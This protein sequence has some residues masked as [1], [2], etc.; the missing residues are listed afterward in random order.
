MTIFIY[1]LYTLTW[2]NLNNTPLNFNGGKVK[3]FFSNWETLTSD[4]WILQTVLGYAIE[5]NSLPHQERAIPSLSF[6]EA[7][8]KQ[9]NIEIEKLL[10][11][12]VIYKVPRCQGEYISNFFLRPKK[13]NT[14]RLIFNVKELNKHIEYHHFKMDTFKTA[15]QL[16]KQDCWFASV[17]LKDAYYSVNVDPSHRKFLRF[18]WKDECYEFSCLPMGLTSSPR[19]FTKLLKPV[20]SNLHQN[21]FASVIYIDDTLLAGDTYDECQKNVAHTVSLLDMLG[22]TVHPE[23]SVLKPVQKIAFLGFELNSVNMTVKLLSGKADDIANECAVLLRKREIKIQE[24]AQIIGKMVAAEPAVQYA[25]LHYKEL[26]IEKDKQLKYNK[27]DYNAKFMLTANAI[28]ELNWWKNNIHTSYMPLVLPEISI[29]IQTD[30]SGHGWGAFMPETGQKTGGHWSYIE[31]SAHINILELTAAFL[32][33]Q[34]FCASKT[35]VHICLQM[36]NMVAVLYVN[37]MGGRKTE[38]NALCKQIWNWCINRDIWVSASHLPGEQNIHADRLSRKLNDD[39]EWMLNKNIFNDIYAIFNLEGNTDLFASR[40]N[41]QLPKYV[42]YLPDPNAWAVDA[43]SMSWTNIDLMYIFPPFSVIGQV[44]TKINKDQ[45]EAVL[46]APIWPAQCWF[47]V[48]L[49]MICQQ[50][51]LIPKNKN[52]LIMPTDEKRVHHLKKL[53]LG[54]FRLSGNFSKTKTYRRKLSIQSPAPGDQLHE[55]NIGHISKNG[56][57]FVVESRQIHL[58]HL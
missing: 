7:E 48:L 44:L 53:R 13:D 54:C 37:N 47:P 5:F 36:D 51:Y 23:K 46:I 4:K 1:L 25:P 41:H 21:G 33:L 43:F 58:I 56:C 14:Y 57:V 12:Q 16:V 11:K 50:S 40:L 34:S 19:V 3:D 26:E 15:L 38:L 10:Q 22:F 39:M 42:S 32:A 17:D 55:N 31:Q 30:S 8:T 45:A 29:T 52:T 20:F 28:A 35:N 2:E 27:G 9:V 18:L 6:N 49:K 24:F